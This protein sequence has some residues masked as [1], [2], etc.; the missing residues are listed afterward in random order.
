MERPCSRANCRARSLWLDE[1]TLALNVLDRGFS[2]LTGEL[3]FNQGAPVGFLFA[4]K[5]LTIFIGS[6][7]YALRLFPLVCSLASIY[8]FSLLARRL[9]PDYAVPIAL[10]LFATASG[11]IY[12]ASVLKQ[13]SS[14]VAMALFLTL[15]AESIV[16]N[17]VGYRGTSLP[18]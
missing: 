5:V 13:Y 12:Y 15:V 16:D 10:L 8:L 3:D 14:D 2:S 18:L 7:E 1:A 6:S 17:G 11:L 4:E 9:L